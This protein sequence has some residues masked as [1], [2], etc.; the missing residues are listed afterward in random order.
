MYF[1]SQFL[2]EMKIMP[3][4]ISIRALKNPE[5]FLLSTNVKA[6]PESFYFLL[7]ASL[8]QPKIMSK[9]IMKKVNRLLDKF[10]YIAF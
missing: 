6:N 3:K 2:N 8:T 10:V 5:F 4:L 1:M 9:I 7:W